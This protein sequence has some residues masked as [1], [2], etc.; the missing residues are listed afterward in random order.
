MEAPRSRAWTVLAGG[1][2][3][4]QAVLGIHLSLYPTARQ[5]RA[6]PSHLAPS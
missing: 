3:F 4:L 5:T 1:T 6:V 2:S